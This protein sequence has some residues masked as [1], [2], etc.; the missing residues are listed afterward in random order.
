MYVCI[1]KT[2]VKNVQQMK[3]NKVELWE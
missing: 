3:Y 2:P 1:Y